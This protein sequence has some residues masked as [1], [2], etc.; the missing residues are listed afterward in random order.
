MA[1]NPVAAVAQSVAWHVMKIAMKRSRGGGKR[2]N[3]N[4]YQAILRRTIMLS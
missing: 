3:A 1:A 4:V 2:V